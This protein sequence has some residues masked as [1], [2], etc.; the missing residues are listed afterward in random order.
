MK[1]KKIQIWG[2]LLIMAIVTVSGC[3]NNQTTSNTTADPNTIIIQDFAFQPSTLTVSAGTTVTWINR[4]GTNH[5][6]ASDTGVFSSGT[7]NQGESYSYT[8]NQ[9]GSYPYHCTVHPS[10][11]GTVIVN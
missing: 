8:F 3:A 2:L 1:E 5:P 9:T 6:V 7:L 4:D 11:T 10:M